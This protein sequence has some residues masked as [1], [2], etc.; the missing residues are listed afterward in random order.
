MEKDAIVNHTAHGLPTVT[1]FTETFV[2]AALF[3][4]V[5]VLAGLFRNTARFHALGLQPLAA[6]LFA[7]G[8]LATALR[9]LLAPAGAAAPAT[10]AGAA[11]AA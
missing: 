3:L 10:P 4:V 6:L 2:M 11:R 7:L 5:C 8:Y 9:D 1:G